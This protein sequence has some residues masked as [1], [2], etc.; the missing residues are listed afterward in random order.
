MPVYRTCVTGI[1]EI[2]EL[3]F[4]HIDV[5]LD[6]LPLD[7]AWETYLE[8][9]QAWKEDN[10]GGWRAREQ[11]ALHIPAF[12][13]TFHDLM[14]DQVLGMLKDALLDPFAAVRDAATKGIPEAYEI[15]GD[16]SDIARRFRDGLLS[17]GK[18]PRF[19]QRQTFVR[20]L[21][22]FVKPP[23]NRQA[24]EDFFLPFLGSLSRDVVDVRLGLAQTVADLF[25]VGK[26]SMKV[27]LT[28]GAF[29]ADKVHAPKA[30]L[31]L[32]K[33]LA[34]DEAVDVRNTIKHVNLDHLEE[35]DTVPYEIKS[36]KVAKRAVL[37]SDLVPDHAPVQ[38]VPLPDNITLS[39]D[40]S[41]PSNDRPERSPTTGSGTPRDPKPRSSPSDSQTSQPLISPTT[42]TFHHRIRID[43]RPSA[44]MTNHME[45]MQLDTS[46]LTPTT[47]GTARIQNRA[48]ARESGEG[49]YIS[50]PSP[51]EPAGGMDPFSISFAQA[52]PEGSP[53]AQTRGLESPGSSNE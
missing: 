7:L 44:E 31:D 49:H 47:P 14:D 30:I 1:D 26:S 10:L 6:R 42:G 5:F 9:A 32:A 13:K 34:Q 11:L 24:F 46:L 38:P 39:E 8:L 40:P 22:E 15:L 48:R 52:T 4:E 28:I 2:R 19:R 35:N 17:L 51:N 3:V 12:F 53:A 27:L 36:P 25:V 43:R 33:L 18:S 23:P 29:Y 45:K 50:S 37:P 20:C 41:S 21:R 16:E